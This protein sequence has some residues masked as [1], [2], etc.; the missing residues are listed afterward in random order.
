[1]GSPPPLAQ[2]SGGVTVIEVNQR[3]VFLREGMHSREIRDHSV[4]RERAIC[5]DQLMPRSRRHRF[6]QFHIEVGEVIVGVTK[7]LGLAKPDT[8]NDRGVIQGIRN[9][10]IFG[11]KNGF[12]KSTIGIK[13]GRVKNGIFRAQKLRKRFLKLAMQGLR[14]A[15]EPNR[16]QAKSVGAH[17]CTRRFTHLG[18]IGQTQ[19]IVRAHVDHATPVIESNLGILGR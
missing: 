2:K 13:T 8:I 9:H 6:L 14:S 19:V 4:H 15:N 17:R 16:S 18:M 10:R 12:K 7:T 1:M 3:S 5:R 11:R